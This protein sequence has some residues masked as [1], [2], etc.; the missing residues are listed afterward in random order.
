MGNIDRSGSLITG[1]FDGS[2]FHGINP[3]K[4]INNTRIY[5]RRKQHLSNN[6]LIKNFYEEF[7]FGMVV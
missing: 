4:S 6:R 1:F 7:L 3:E 2:G 5:H